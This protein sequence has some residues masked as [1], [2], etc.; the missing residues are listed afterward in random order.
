MRRCRSTRRSRSRRGGPGGRG[1]GLAIALGLALPHSFFEDW[2][3]L[4][5]PGA[6]MAARALDRAV[7]APAARADVV[8][9][10][11]RG[12]T[13]A[14]WRRS[15]GCTGSAR[16]SQ[17]CSSRCG[18]AAPPPAA[19]PEGPHSG[20][21]PTGTRRARDGRVEGNRSR[22]RQGPDRGGR[23][24][25]DHLR[26]QER[27]EEAAGRSGRPASPTT[28]GTPTGSACSC[29]RSSTTSGR[30]RS[31]SQHGRPAALR[32][33]WASARR[34]ARGVR[35]ARARAAGVRRGDAA[36]DAPPPLGPDPQRQLDGGP[37]ADPE[38]RAQQ[39]QPLRRARRRGRRSRARPRSRA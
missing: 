10:G 8:R 30:S 12:H 34:V 6:W 19:S 14:R 21:R 26:S 7:A 36:G 16:R 3:W 31:S 17:S 5:G 2:G 13:R 37:R 29:T 27:I 23:D 15:P 11:A 4:A 24:R 38:P 28:P 1:P 20:S 39:R 32:T 33:R 18:A 35:R 9:G 25:R 22:H